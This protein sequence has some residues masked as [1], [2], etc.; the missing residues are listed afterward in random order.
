MR[1]HNDVIAPFR[2]L[3]GDIV[4]HQTPGDDIA[5]LLNL[6]FIKLLH[7]GKRRDHQPC[8]FSILPRHTGKRHRCHLT[9]KI[10]RS[11]CTREGQYRIRVV[12]Q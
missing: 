2:L 8:I 5:Q 10:G 12:R 11:G 7:L 4:A 3:V 9:G 6:I 1:A